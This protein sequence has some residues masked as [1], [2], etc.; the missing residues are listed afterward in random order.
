MGGGGV[1]PYYQHNGITIYH[2]DWRSID[3]PAADLVL[4]DPPYGDS[5]D[6][7]YTRFT[8]GVAAE[9]SSHAA[10][11]GDDESYDP[12]PLLK[13]GKEHILWGC[14]RYSE[15]LPVGALLVWDKRAPSGSKNVMS[16]AEVAWFSR[17]RGVY[18]FSHTWDGFNRASERQTAYHPS[19]KPVA[20]MRWCLQRARLAP[21][22]LVFDPYMGSGP[23]AQA[24]KELG[25]R[26]V[27]CDL[28][29]QYCDI[30]ARRLSQEVMELV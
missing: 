1:K 5:H 29:E 22:A 9:R 18:I 7:D 10:I 21:G 28:V 6:T 25:F 24:C 16:D 13:V 15:H 17:G 11:A 23:V 20:L 30:A 12:R 8:G 2:G 3:P 14:N 27:G 19:Q 26:Y 4:A